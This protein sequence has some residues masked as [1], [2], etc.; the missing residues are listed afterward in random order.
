MLVVN[1]DAPHPIF[2]IINRAEARWHAKL[3]S[4]SRTLEEAVS[5]YIR[6]Y[7]R[8]PPKGFDAWWR[9]AEL[10]NVQLPDEYDQIWSD[11]EPFWGMDPVDLNRL[12]LQHEGH[13]DSFTLGK[14]EGESIKLLNVSV[15]D[16]SHWEDKN[17]LRG[18]EDIL[19]LLQDVQHHLPPFRAVVSPHDNPTLF[20]DFD[21]KSLALKAASKHSYL[22]LS[23]IV[24]DQR[25]EEWSSACA[26][27]SPARQSKR[28]ATLS[29]RKTFIHHHHKTMD[30][31][32]HP[33]L[34]EI[35]GEFLS[36]SEP[37]AQSVMI[38]RFA[39]APTTL[40]HDIRIPTLLSWVDDIV[41]QSD[42]PPWE[43]RLD[44][45]LSWRG[46]N[47]GMWHAPETRWRNAQRARLVD[48][49]RNLNGTVRVLIPS[50][51]REARVGEGVEIGRQ[52]INPAMMDITFAGAPIGCPPLFC[53]ELLHMF[54]WRQR[55]NPEEAG[56]F[57]YVIDVSLV[58]P[59]SLTTM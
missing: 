58:C 30:P 20:S 53:D 34:L 11:L 40:H 13:I 14:N 24:P 16:P 55:Q 33:Q 1:P 5:E 37:T 32:T 54:E 21:S 22:N 19:D 51:S 35:H 49:S 27:S 46:S 3:G 26:P 7:R 8:A 47:T 39:Y 4:A 56:N 31:C 38:P 36:H 52:K 18:A 17:L 25:I 2:D 9:Y 57:K 44:E 10:H 28:N 6:R 50:G 43:G 42:N 45:S 41:P 29:S 59:R 12:Q 15:S 23:N 48:F